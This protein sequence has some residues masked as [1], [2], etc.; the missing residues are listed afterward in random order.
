MSKF[1]MYRNLWITFLCTALW[2]GSTFTF[3]LWG[4]LHG[5]FLTLE[6]VINYKSIFSNRY[7]TFLLISLSWVPFFSENISSTIN[8]YLSLTNYQ[9]LNDN[10]LPLFAQALDFKLLIAYVVCISSLLVKKEF[11]YPNLIY[12]FITLILAILLVMSSTVD[13]F[14][15]YRF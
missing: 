5:L 11:Y 7:I 6:K 13:P 15:Y 1:K 14:I 12:V 3:I 4:F 10:F 2:H 8:I 9:L